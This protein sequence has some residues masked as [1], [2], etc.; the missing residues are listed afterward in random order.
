MKWGRGHIAD[1]SE[2]IG[3]IDNHE[4]HP[5]VG[6]GSEISAGVSVPISEVTLLAPIRPGKFIGLWNNYKAAA[7]VGSSR[8]DLQACKLEYSI[9]SPK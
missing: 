1:G 6:L 9:V 2:I 4:F 7:E 8:V 3:V 5:R